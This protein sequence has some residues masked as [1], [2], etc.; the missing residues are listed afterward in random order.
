MDPTK[1]EMERA[2]VLADKLLPALDFLGWLLRPLFRCRPLRS[3]V[4]KTWGGRVGVI[5]RHAAQGD[6]E[7]AAALAIQA[8]KDCRQGSRSDWR[9]SGRDHW[10]FFVRLAAGSAGRC[11]S[12]RLKQEVIQL[13]GVESEPARGLNAAEAFLEFARWAYDEGELDAAIAY[14]EQA[15][16]ADES[17]G[18]PDFMLGWYRLASGDGEPLRHF[19]R[20]VGK[21]PGLYFQIAKDP[22]CKSHPH[23]MQALR[24]LSAPHLVA[25]GQDPVEA[26]RRTA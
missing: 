3:K 23:L 14:A 16:A 8:A 13:A 22:L 12:S 21:D 6:N 7:T 17:W 11:G 2:S 5:S 20:A 25:P 15:A 24:S 4:A 9:A 26:E 18:E 1:A 10:W 19:A